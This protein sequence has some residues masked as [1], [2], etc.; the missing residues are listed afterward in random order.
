MSADRIISEN[1]E[2]VSGKVRVELAW[3]WENTDRGTLTICPDTTAPINAIKIEV[4]AG[5]TANLA[6][7]LA[8]LEHVISLDA[9]ALAEAAERLDA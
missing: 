6:S 2:T 8:M 9:D 3:D 5:E 7:A 4:A 1:V